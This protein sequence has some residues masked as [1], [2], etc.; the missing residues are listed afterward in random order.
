[1]LSARDLCAA[2]RGFKALLSFLFRKVFGFP[3]DHRVCNTMIETP[4]SNKARREAIASARE[5]LNA[6]SFGNDSW[7]VILQYSDG[8]PTLQTA[9][10]AIAL[11]LGSILEQGLELSILSHCVLGWNTAEAEAEQRKLFSG[12]EDGAMNFAV[13]IRLAYALGVY[14]PA[15]RSDL[16]MMRNI[17]NLFAH[18]RGHLTFDDAVASNLCA[19]IKWISQYPWGGLVGPEPASPRAQYIAT[20][21]HLFPFLTV[22]VGMPIRYKDSMSAF[23]EMYA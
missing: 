10:R 13:K 2:K 9:D 5:R 16:D 8:A 4:S 20:V 1:M 14:G 18:D 6:R 23:S 22:G 7:Q 11:V 12:G 17:R 3:V 15:T 19:Q 21:K